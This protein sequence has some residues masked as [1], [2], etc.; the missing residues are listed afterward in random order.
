M[1]VHKLQH[2]LV[3]KSLF[4]V[5]QFNNIFQFQS[6]NLRMGSSSRIKKASQKQAQIPYLSRYLKRTRQ[7]QV[8]EEFHS[9]GRNYRQRVHRRWSN[10]LL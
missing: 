4:L 10:F 7:E 8:P 5:E 6:I 2:Y 1:E 9:C 3:K